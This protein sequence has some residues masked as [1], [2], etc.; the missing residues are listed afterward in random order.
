MYVYKMGDSYRMTKLT[1]KF[2]DRE[3]YTIRPSKQVVNEYRE[4][5]ARK[6]TG[7]S[8]FCRRRND[9]ELRS[10]MYNHI[11]N[12][13]MEELKEFRP[14]RFFKEYKNDTLLQTT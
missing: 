2:I 10:I 5:L 13:K 14:L 3:R 1:R 6:K 4:T 11:E 7:I 8:Q 9:P 12:L